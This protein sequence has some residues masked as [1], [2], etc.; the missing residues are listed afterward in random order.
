[1]SYTA[2]YRKFR[3]T[4]FS[5]IVGQEHITRTLRNQ[6]IAN[7]VGHAYL[8]TGGRGTGK[9]SAAKILA[10]AINCLNPQ[11]GEPCNE[12][13]ICKAA[14]QGSLTDIVEMDAA[15]NNS[16]EDIRSIREEV[17][18]LPTVAKYR[19]YI[20]D[21]VHMLSVGAFNALLKTLE[22]PPEHVKFILATTEPQK[23][24]A[25]ILSRCQRFDYKKISPENVK[26]RL[27][28]I[29]KES[30]I[31]ITDE[32][33]KTISILAEGAM[34]DGLSILERC[35]QEG[36]DLIDEDKVKELV[37]IPKVEYINKIVNS[38]TDGNVDET[39]QNIDVVISDGKDLNNLIWE[40]IKYVKDILVYKS[41][42][43]LSLYNEEELSKIKE[44]SDKSSKEQLLRMIYSL[45]ELASDLKMT[46]QKTIMLEVGIMKLCNFYNESDYQTNNDSSANMQNTSNVYKNFENVSSTGS[47]ELKTENADIIDLKNKIKQLDSKIDKISNLVINNSA[48]N[49]DNSV[50]KSAPA[51]K[52]VTRTVQKGPR[53]IVKNIAPVGKKAEGWGKLVNG[54]KE[55]GKIMLYT[56]LMNTTATE[57]NDMTVGIVFP[58]GIT[59]FGKSILDK[60]ES[61]NE[62][63]KLISLEYGKPMQ[64]KYIDAKQ[65][66][67]TTDIVGE[68]TKEIGMPINVIDE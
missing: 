17:N 49:V 22:E 15:S 9:T 33:L 68:I 25:T 5:E 2:L 7:R 8:L 43:K 21:E 11:D 26:L 32:A 16:V 50:E 56:N 44:I 4:K 31:N 23:L 64:V 18:F 39:L 38:V 55:S 34:R 40:I 53:N 66:E 45:S 12:C 67:K 61:V 24:P 30:N 65:P 63:T 10:R 13:E 28:Y 6:I 29:C 20:I 3:P 54:L 37:G 42:G 51:R 14:I 1:M 57:V 58:N 47:G 52:N 19:V 59:P 35:V 27:D 48:T 62:L 60:P 46:T 36:E 41:S